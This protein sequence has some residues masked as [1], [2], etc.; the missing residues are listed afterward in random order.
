MAKLDVDEIVKKHFERIYQNR[1][2]P[3]IDE[4]ATL[5][6]ENEVLR[7]DCKRYRDMA[8]KMKKERDRAI[9]ILKEVRGY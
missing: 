6:K 8:Q 2:K 5:G 4:N 7:K 1:I 9:S 3:I